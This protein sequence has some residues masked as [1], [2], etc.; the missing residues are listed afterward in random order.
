MSGESSSP[1]AQARPPPSPRVPSSK[2]EKLVGAVERAIERIYEA[3]RAAN[4]SPWRRLFGKAIKQIKNGPAA[5][6]SVARPGTK[7]DE[8]ERAKKGAGVPA[9]VSSSVHRQLSEA[10]G[11]GDGEQVEQAAALEKPV[12]AAMM[13]SALARIQVGDAGE[14]EVF[15]EMEQALKGLMDVSF[16]AKDPVVPAEFVSKWSRGSESWSQ[17]D[18]I[19]DPHILTSG[20]SVDTDSP[21]SCPLR[22]L[23]NVYSQFQITSSMMS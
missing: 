1:P 15:A 16:K 18:I 14:A 10:S 5:S 21:T 22:M 23:A 17:M 12:Y 2:E 20:H 3:K 6:K 19:A 11:E 9:G 7:Q 8:R 4:L 13:K